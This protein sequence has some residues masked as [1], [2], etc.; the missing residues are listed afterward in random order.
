VT[1]VAISASYGAAGGIIAAAVAERLGV[2][3]TDRA[4]PLARDSRVTVPDDAIS[5]F[6]GQTTAG[7]IERVLS[8][9]LTGDAGIAIPVPDGVMIP[10]DFRRATEKVLLQQSATGEGV[11][12][13]RAAVVV[14]R[15]DPNA[16][17]VRLDGAPDLRARQ[18][19]R[20]QGVDETTAKR[21]LRRLDS[22]HRAYFKHFYGADLD[23]PRLYHLVLDSTKL[24][25]DLCVDL[26]VLAA[27]SVDAVSWGS[28]CGHELRRLRPCE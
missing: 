6:D 9:F 10:D 12:L 7:W 18:A 5:T 8:A 21:M 26:I 15:E 28:G 3:F 4:I 1:V 13:G 25:T 22:A 17:R 19:A 16:L 20:L 11:L 24:S 14:L 23:D 2:P 27:A